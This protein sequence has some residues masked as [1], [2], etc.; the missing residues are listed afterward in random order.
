[1]N[2]INKK[3][4]PK[5][6]TVYTDIIFMVLALRCLCHSHGVALKA[7]NLPAQ[8]NISYPTDTSFLV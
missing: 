3:M 8:D 6:S 5:W 4:C 7:E 2:E 1:M